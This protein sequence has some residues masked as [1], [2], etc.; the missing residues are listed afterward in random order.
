M[1]RLITLLVAILVSVGLLRSIDAQSTPHSRDT[2]PL[3][4]WHTENDPA[5]QARFKTIGDVFRKATGREVTYEYVTWGQLSKQLFL[6]LESGDDSLLPDITHL[7]PYMA[8]SLFR[9]S[10]LTDISDVVKAIEAN[11]SV[12]KQV[13]SLQEFDGRYYGIAQH[14]GVSFIIYRQDHLDAIAAKPPKTWDE[15]FAVCERLK[16]HFTAIDYHPVTAP[17][18]SPF[19][20]EIVFNEL[21]NSLGGAIIKGSPATLDLRNKEVVKVLETIKRL[22]E[23][24]SPTRFRRTE[25][26]EQFRHLESGQAT[27][28]MF[29]G[30]RAF[31]T[32]EANDPTA[33]PEK[34]RCMEPPTFG[35][36]PSFTSL[37]CEPFVILR[38][39]DQGRI[40]ESKEWLK[41][42]YAHEYREFCESVPI[43]LV[44]I[45]PALDSEYAKNPSVIKWRPWYEQAMRM[46]T[47]DRTVPYFQQRGAP[48][49][50]DFLF[51]FHNRGIIHQM[52]LDVVGGV[53]VG[54]ATEKAQSKA[55][56]IVR[57]RRRDEAP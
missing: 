19:F 51:A 4:I 32:F 26:L 16:G 15:F 24:A 20:I 37:D 38:R 6:A 8:Y 23:F 30:A 25:Y 43:Q 14:V 27:F 47:Q 44:P 41:T 36:H 50:V 17:G 34:Y 33:S 2:R 42:F 7:E 29:A 53:D 3:L 11:A 45:F 56:L 35:D 28:I 54:T 57:D 21:L 40:N 31:K 12:R 39:S 10:A 22:A 55:A 48:T 46:I 9:R 52:I 1:K 18:V 5:T 13:L 49:E